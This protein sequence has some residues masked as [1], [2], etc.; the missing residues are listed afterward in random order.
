LI[1]LEKLVKA[2]FEMTGRFDKFPYSD[3]LRE[4]VKGKDMDMT[5]A[6]YSLLGYKHDAQLSSS[7]RFK[8]RKMYSSGKRSELMSIFKVSKTAD[9]VKVLKDMDCITDKTLPKVEATG[10]PAIHLTL[11]LILA[12]YLSFNEEKALSTTEGNMLV[13]K[14][15]KKYRFV[16][17]KET[18][19]FLA[20]ETFKRVL[21]VVMPEIVYKHKC[22]PA[23]SQGVFFVPIKPSVEELSMIVNNAVMHSLRRSLKVPEQVYSYVTRNALTYQIRESEEYLRLIDYA[24]ALGMTVSEVFEN[25]GLRYVDNLKYFEE[26]K[27]VFYVT[28]V[29]K[30]IVYGI[31]S[32]SEKDSITLTERQI[33]ELLKHD[34]LKTLT[35]DDPKGASVY[36]GKKQYVNNIFD[37]AAQIRQM[38]AFQ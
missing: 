24:H 21:K 37:F 2:H 14:Y 6:F 22:L 18:E 34:A 3:M 35:W 5:D 29:E 20:S 30:Y 36:I 27:C 9:L 25:C 26:T 4:Y 1:I 32:V 23:I 19:D 7:D 8:Y 28:G 33:A 17:L 10:M 16:S 15:L 38:E 13:S 31:N 11:S 12:N